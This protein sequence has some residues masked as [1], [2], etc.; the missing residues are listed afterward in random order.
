MAEPASALRRP[1]TLG[2]FLVVAS[3][4]K[5]NREGRSSVPSRFLTIVVM[6]KPLEARPRFRRNL[7]YDDS[8]VESESAGSATRVVVPLI[9]RRTAP[10]RSAESR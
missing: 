1:D 10:A 5:K 7:D 2:V 4:T 8:P 3:E 6:W 9:S